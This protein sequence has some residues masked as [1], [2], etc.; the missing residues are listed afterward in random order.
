MIDFQTGS[1]RVTGK[2]TGVVFVL[3]LSAL[4]AVTSLSTDIYLPAMPIMA[5]DL[6]G[7]FLSYPA[8]P[9]YEIRLENPITQPINSNS[10]HTLA[11][12]SVLLPAYSLFRKHVQD[13]DRKYIPA[14]HELPGFPNARPVA[15]KTPNG[16]GKLR[17]RWKDERGIILEWDSKKGEIEKY[18]KTG[19]H[20]GAFNP[21]TGEQKK[22]PTKGR[23]I[24]EYL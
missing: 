16:S 17:R 2:T 7:G 14:P 12:Q 1:Q 9:S 20:L 19:K 4:M 18:T 13:G 21:I 3:I 8:E 10:L 15:G 6:Q 22:G 11:A 5:K 23:S 24:K